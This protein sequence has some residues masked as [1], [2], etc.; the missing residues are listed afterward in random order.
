LE[1]RD[2]RELEREMEEDR[3]ALEEEQERDKAAMEE[4]KRL[5]EEEAGREGD[6]V[7]EESAKENDGE[8]DAGDAEGFVVEI[9]QA[10]PKKAKRRGKKMGAKLQRKGLKE[11]GVL[12][13]RGGTA[14]TGRHE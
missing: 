5:R 2:P 3:K 1:L 11:K 10:E 7:V 14:G 13:G 12:G 8:V 9:D 6:A 4:A